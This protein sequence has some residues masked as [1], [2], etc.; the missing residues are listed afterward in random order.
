MEEGCARCFVTAGRG[1]TELVCAELRLAGMLSVEPLREADGKVFFSNPPTVPLPSL[2]RLRNVERVFLLVERWQPVPPAL[3]GSGS[4]PSATERS[5]CYRALRELCL[6]LD[7]AG[8]LG[9]WA[10]SLPEAERA[11]AASKTFRVCAKVRGDPKRVFSSQ[12]VA[13]ALTEALAPRLAELG[14]REAEGFDV[15]CAEVYVHISDT[16]VVRAQRIPVCLGRAVRA[17]GQVVGLP[18]F[19]SLGPLSSRAYTQHLGGLRSTVAYSVALLGLQCAMETLARG[20]DSVLRVVDPM[21]GARARTRGPAGEWTGCVAQVWALSLSRPRWRGRSM[22][23]WVATATRRSSS[24][25]P[26]M[27]CVHMCRLAST[28]ASGTPGCCRC[29]PAART[30]S[31]ATSR[32]G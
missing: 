18:L 21:A 3:L 16:F 24:V 31:S 30:W 29:P 10:A 2:Q 6:S 13:A 20:R 25:Q 17:C 26:S 9:W 27:R 22:R 8:A 15:Q 28:G 4:E 5:Q 12:R 14:L 19:R 11:S 7:W 23:T 32:S 1:L